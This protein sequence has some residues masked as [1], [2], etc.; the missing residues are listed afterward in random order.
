MGLIRRHIPTIEL[1]DG[2]G[3]E[4]AKSIM[5]TDTHHKEYAVQFDVDGQ[6]VTVGGCAKGAGMIHPDMATMLAFVTTD[7]DVHQAVLQSSISNAV[8]RTFN[9]IDVDGDQSTNDTVALLANGASGA[10]TL[11]TA[12]PMYAKRL[13]GTQF[14]TAVEQVCRNLAISLARDGEGAQHLITAVVKGAHSD[15]D[16]RQAARSIV[17][18]MLVKTAVYGRD[19]NWGRIMM[20]VGATGIP[21]DESKIAIYINDIHIVDEGKAIAFNTQSVVSAL[22]DA[23]VNITVDLQVGAGSGTAWGSDLTEEYVVFNSAYTT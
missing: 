14:Q 4:F 19:P 21:L 7:A 16:A 6:T 11:T 18:S 8:K 3:T 23:D 1:S 13:D 2:G 15:D 22:G 12:D 10:R 9:Q 17:S 20:A 5:T